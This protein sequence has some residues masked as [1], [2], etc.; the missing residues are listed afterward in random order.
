MS[1]SRVSGWLWAALVPFLAGVASGQQQLPPTFEF[2]LSNPGARSMGF[3]GAF[4]ALADDATAALA[5]PAG[6]V[7]LSEPEVSLELRHWA[8]STPYVSGGRIFGPPTGIGL[9]T[10]EGLRTSRSESNR[11]GLSF[12]S[13]VFPRERWSV[14]VYRHQLA[15]FG[16]EGEIEGLYSGPWPGIG[17]RREFDVRKTLNLDIFSWAVAGAL[18]VTDRLS[19]GLGFSYF[20]GRMELFADS[21]GKYGFGVP[22]EEFFYPRPF[23][24]TDVVSSFDVRIDDTDVGVHAGFLWSIDSSWSVGGFYREAPEFEGSVLET[25]G[26]NWPFDR[27]PDD[28]L[29]QSVG[30]V[31]FP[32]VWGLGT[33]WRSGQRR[34]TVSMELDHI[35]YSNVWESVGGVSADDVLE[36]HLGGEYVFL[37]SKP[38]VGV[39]LGTWLDP[40]HQVYSEGSS[41]VAEAVLQRGSDEWHVTAGVGLAFAAFNVDFGLDL[42]D[43]VDQFSVSAIY[44]F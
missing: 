14:A 23:D 17:L 9:D 21:H 27:P 11:T 15:D 38:M 34:L 6:L 42:S 36:V 7:Q 12:L 2:S 35:A 5:N 24:E 22:P 1:G 3:G 4:A 18:R 19:L 20:V 41:Y 31:R 43:P 29:D 16:F 10:T 44:S 30:Q 39:R 26:P 40:D 33:A 37:G 8:Y 32:D 25:A 28:V 13:F